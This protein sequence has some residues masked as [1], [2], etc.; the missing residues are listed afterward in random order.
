MEREE[1]RLARKGNEGGKRKERKTWNR[2]RGKRKKR[3]TGCGGV[4]GK[5]RGEK[6]RTGEQGEKREEGNC[7]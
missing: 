4:R 7:R 3:L 2:G 1:V 5:G 6:D